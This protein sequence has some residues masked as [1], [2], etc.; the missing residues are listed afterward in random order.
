MR[1]LFY[2]VLT[3]KTIK[4]NALFVTNLRRCPKIQMPPFSYRSFLTEDSKE[5]FRGYFERK[6]SKVTKFFPKI[7]VKWKYMF[8]LWN[9][10]IPRIHFFDTISRKINWFGSVSD[11]TAYF[12][13]DFNSNLLIENQNYINTM[14]S[15][16]QI[17]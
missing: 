3:I 8:I 15:H 14:K 7:T 13:H 11:V 2:W 4:L 1:K 5:I 6:S 10:F 9:N 16:G 12:Q 17:F